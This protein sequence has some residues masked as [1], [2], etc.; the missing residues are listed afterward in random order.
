MSMAPIAALKHKDVLV[1]LALV[2][3]MGCVFANLVDYQGASTC[4]GLLT[5]VF[6][7]AE[8]HVFLSEDDAAF[9][10]FICFVYPEWSLLAAPT[11]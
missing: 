9:F 8:A 2:N 11:A 7:A 4:L 3:N 1:V 6:E 5:D 10:Y